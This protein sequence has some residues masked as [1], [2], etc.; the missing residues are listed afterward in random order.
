[1]RFGL[2]RFTTEEQVECVVAEVVRV[3][4]HLRAMSPAYELHRHERQQGVLGTA[5]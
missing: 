2:G 1:L 4:R 5:G 3:V